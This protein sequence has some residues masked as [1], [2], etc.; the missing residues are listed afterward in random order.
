MQV[1]ASIE[2]KLE[3][4]LA[5]VRLDVIDDSARHAGHAGSRP[6]GET[7]FR[8]EIVSEAFAGKSR[9]DRHRMV[10]AVLAEELAGRVH[11]LQ[12]ATLT[13]GEA[14]SKS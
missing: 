1:R 6:E 10:N 11:A 5:P 8:V 4:A 7:H 2:R 14:A 12:L 9:V 3:Q 13:P